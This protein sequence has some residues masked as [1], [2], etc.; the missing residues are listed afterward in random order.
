VKHLRKCLGWIGISAG[1]LIAILL[2][3]DA[4]FLW[5]A[6]TRLARRLD[7]L[8]KSGEP[9]RIADLAHAPIP[10]EKNAVVFLRRAASLLDA[11]EKELAA[12]YPKAGYPAPTEPLPRADQE[13]LGK[14]F[15]AYPEL[16]PL[17]EQAA[18]SPDSDPQFDCT[19]PADRFPE[20][21]MQ[22]SSR[23]RALGRVLR[24]RSAWLLS[25]GRSDEALA[26]Q[27]LTLRLARHWRQEPLI[28]GYLV[29]AACE[30]V[31]ME[32]VNQVL[33]AGPVAATARQTLDAELAL[34]DTM[35]G[36]NRALQTERAFSLS[37]VRELP[38]SRFWVTR[39]FY[40][41]VTLRLLDCYDR[42]LEQGTKP[43]IEVSHDTSRRSAGGGG[44]NLYG[45]LVTLLEPSLAAVR[46]P[47]ERVRAM[48]RSLRILNALQVRA[49]AS[50]DGVPQLTELGLPSAATVDP[51][52]GE[53]L[54]VQK[55]GHGWKVFSVG[56]N[57]LDDGGKLDGR[58]DIGVGPADTPV[59]SDRSDRSDAQPA[60]TAGS[61]RV[62]N[63]STGRS[64][65]GGAAA[66][67]P[68]IRLIPASSP[69]RYHS[70]G[71][72]SPAWAR[73]QSPYR[74]LAAG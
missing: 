64:G 46:E 68:V 10:P 50:N 33:R 7:A 57:L 70:P 55:L 51:F 49:P 47:A 20:A 32:G 69:R 14:L 72:E 53:P 31:A 5:S 27:V 62:P 39:G 61:S 24:A 12:S 3:L 54:R 59:R 19:L 73:T 8:R 37:S 9:L 1:A 36:Y 2:L 22:H 29:T 15:A 26:T 23:H 48:S 25:Q 38:G 44:L 58:T 34:H 63:Y 71:L 6:G 67:S 66:E 74:Q 56:S 30:Q 16:M 45:A 42:Y 17:L 11:V 60:P 28:I 65:A 52:N 13:K 43:F 4:V 41:D 40:D 21:Y 18:D 35:E